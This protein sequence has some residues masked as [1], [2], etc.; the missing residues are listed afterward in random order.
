MGEPGV[1]EASDGP[2]ATPEDA[3]VPA[4]SV[5]SGER[6]FP[7]SKCGAQLRFSPGAFAMRCAHCGSLNEIEASDAEIAELDYESMLLELESNETLVDEIVSACE[8][9]GARIEL[10]KNVTSGTCPFCSRTVVATGR[11]VKHIKPRSLLPFAIDSRGARERFSKWINK[12]WFAPSDL[13]TAATIDGRLNGVYLPYWTYDSGAITDYVGQRGVYYWVTETYTTMV[14]GKPQIRT[15]QVRKTRWY[16]ASG[17]VSDYFDDL[18]V[19]ASTSIQTER[20]HKLGPWDLGSLTP[21]NDEFLAGFRSESYSVQLDGGFEQAKVM[22]IPQ[23]R[24]TI[25]ADIGGD[26]QRIASM[27]THHH[28]ITFKHLLLPA[29]VCAYRYKEKLYQ[30]LVNAR[31]GEV[32]GDRP[33][34]WVKISLSV[35]VA[36]VVVIAIVAVIAIKSTA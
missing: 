1:H 24:S 16:P 27:D 36:I 11:S 25:C 6:R 9:C 14:N 29:W 18:L 12:L 28:S 10:A 33:W 26:T 7:C 21:Y 13:K 32:I 35:L 34:S 15:R 31:T 4:E 3:P 22:M 5:P 19:P 2:E 30:I 20:L 23:I 8:S 17:R